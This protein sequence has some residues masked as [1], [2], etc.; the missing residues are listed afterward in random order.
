VT[1]DPAAEPK[2]A[3]AFER[4]KYNEDGVYLV[5]PKI[6]SRGTLDFLYGQVSDPVWSADGKRI[7]LKLYRWRDVSETESYWVDDIAVINRDGSGFKKLTRMV[8]GDRL[9]EF[10]W[11]P[12]GRW[13][14][15]VRSKMDPNY[16]FSDFGVWVLKTDGSGTMKKIGDTADINSHVEW[17]PDSR[18]LAYLEPGGLLVIASIETGETQTMDLIDA[19]ADRYRLFDVSADGTAVVY[20]NYSET[21]YSI[22]RADLAGGSSGEEPRVETLFT[23]AIDKNIEVIIPMVGDIALS[24]DGTRL[25]YF[26]TEPGKATLQIFAIGSDGPV[27]VA[28]LTD[29]SPDLARLS[30]NDRLIP[31]A[32][33]WRPGWSSDGKWI[34]YATAVSGE[35]WENGNICIVNAD[36]ALAGTIEPILVAEHG[37]N[38]DWQPV[39]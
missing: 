15:V 6:N 9:W 31:T 14:A 10:S 39:I 27:T 36:Q 17:F 23:G 7:A 1:L 25:I 18:R 4:G 22:R 35:G 11:S 5:T 28:E 13:I 38:P 26:L 16:I 33:N 30:P 2:G 37:R 24:P 3:I 21:E 19:P 34:V 20:L 12:D 29:Y 32:P 8:E